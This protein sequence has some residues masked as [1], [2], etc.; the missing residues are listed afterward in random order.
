MEV[1][2][3]NVSNLS[4]KLLPMEDA[5]LDEDRKLWDFGER[6]DV[7]S[8]HFDS[9]LPV[10]VPHGDGEH[11]LMVFLSNGQLFV[12]ACDKPLEFNSAH[13]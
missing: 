6:R 11:S 8:K 2:S 5:G 4:Q 13:I 7:D 3:F 9:E 12:G 1:S 10:A